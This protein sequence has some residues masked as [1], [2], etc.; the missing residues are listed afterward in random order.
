MTHGGFLSNMRD[1]ARFGLL[2]TPSAN[3]IGADD[4]ISDEHVN[5]LLNDGRP[6]LMKA[7]G[8]PEDA[9]AEIRHNI[10]QWDYVTT[11]SY[12]HLRAHETD[13]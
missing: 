8:L 9:L 13:S 4:V 7:T 11:V 10:Y 1:L 12:T 3:V 6:H 5:F 2:F